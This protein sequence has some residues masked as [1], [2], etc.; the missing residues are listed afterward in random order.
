MRDAVGSAEIEQGL[1]PGGLRDESVQGAE[2]AVRHEDGSG[3]GSQRHH[4]ARPVVL[5]VLARALVLADDVAVVLVQRRT[6]RN[7]R[8]RVRARPEAVHVESRRALTGQR[9]EPLELAEVLGGLR[10]NRV[11]MRVRP[12]GQVDLGA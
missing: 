6:A 3:L 7:P 1:F 12:V 9:S 11:R 5:L 8:L 10:V 4:V 2:V